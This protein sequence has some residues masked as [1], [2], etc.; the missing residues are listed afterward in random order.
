MGNGRS[1]TPVREVGVVGAAEVTVTVTPPEAPRRALSPR[2]CGF[3]GQRPAIYHH[4]VMRGSRRRQPEKPK[5]R[6]SGMS[7]ED[8]LRT[9]GCHLCQIKR[10]LAEQLRL[11]TLREEEIRAWSHV[12]GYELRRHEKGFS[13]N[14]EARGTRIVTTA[15]PHTFRSYETAWP[16]L[17]E[18]GIDEA[19]LAA[20][21]A[22][23]VAPAAEQDPEFVDPGT[24]QR[25]VARFLVRQLV[26]AASAKSFNMP[27]PK[28]QSGGDGS[29]HLFWRIGISEL[30]LQ[31][32]GQTTT[33]Y[34]DRLRDKSCK[35]DASYI[36]LAFPSEGSSESHGVI[37]EWLRDAVAIQ[38]A[39]AAEEARHPPSPP[40]AAKKRVPVKRA[41]V[42]A[43]GAKKRTR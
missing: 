29:V 43:K 30:I 24:T 28:F 34:G 19:I 27:L 3:C 37:V 6:P 31:V 41:K 22:M 18:K 9:L 33:G 36:K 21:M 39:D 25:A 10:H 23:G 32:N 1:K 35:P 13:L 17:S 12:Y 4:A 11:L 2:Q 8:E 5:V 26:R 7:Y 20:D 38:I 42:K 15:A 14:H 40:T 16:L